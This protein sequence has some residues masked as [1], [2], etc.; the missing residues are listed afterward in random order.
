MCRRISVLGPVIVLSA[1][2][3]S[4]VTGASRPASR[5]V[6]AEA[7]ALVRA[8]RASENWVHHV[9]SILIRIESKWTTTA[10]G[11]AARRAKLRKQFPDLP[12]DHFVFSGLKPQTTGILEI[13][14][15]SRRC[16]RLCTGSFYDL[17]IWDGKQAITH[18]KY[19]TSGQEHYSFDKAPQRFVGR[20]FLNDLSWLRAGPHFFWWG[21]ETATIEHFGEPGEFVITGPTIYGGVDCWVLECQRTGFAWRWHVGAKDKLLHG[22]AD[23]CDG[24]PRI[25]H[26][27]FDY[28]ELAP[29]YWFPMT[30]GYIIYD[31][32]KNKRFVRSRRDLR[33][34]EVKVNTPL[35]DNL[36]IMEFK[37]GVEVQDYRYDPPL[38]YKYKAN[39]TPE[40]WQTILDEA[41]R[42][43][44][45]EEASA[46]SQEIPVGPPAPEFPDTTWLNSKPMKWADLKGKVVVLDFWAIWCGPC[47]E[48]LPVMSNLHKKRS[49]T[50]ITVIGIHAPGSEIDSIRKTMKRFDLD[51]PICIDAP[52]PDRSKGFGMMSGRYGVG[53]IPYAFVVDQDGRIAGRGQLNEVLVTAR[54][55]A[56]KS[57]PARE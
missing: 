49:E 23:V 25:E 5:P 45:E 14:F 27:M 22:L 33:I 30:Q 8:V 26:R 15:D 34:V 41:E 50:G 2:I 29:G 56:R 43:K 11:L 53:H 47:Q 54:R 55:I 39:R 48:D 40:E 3:S 10:E 36:F 19:F 18:E 38:F 1:S 17:R 44:R 12:L 37:D 42:Q 16:R 24:N 32:P 13:A 28:R 4:A 46:Q 31:G 35:P 6:D 20:I 21:W 52:P 57:G 51:Y 9:E 7:A